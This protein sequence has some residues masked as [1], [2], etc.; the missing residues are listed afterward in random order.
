MGDWRV[1]GWWGAGSQAETKLSVI[2]AIAIVIII[3]VGMFE[4]GD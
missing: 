2:A 4:R 1:R 3:I